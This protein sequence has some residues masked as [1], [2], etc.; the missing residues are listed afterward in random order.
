MIYPLTFTKP[1]LLRTLFHG[2]LQCG[3]HI[4]KPLRQASHQVLLDS[5][6]VKCFLSMLHTSGVKRNISVRVW[7]KAVM[8]EILKHFQNIRTEMCKNI[9]N[10]LNE[11]APAGRRTLW[12]EIRLPILYLFTPLSTCTMTLL[13]S[14]LPLVLVLLYFRAQNSAEEVACSSCIP[15]TAWE[16]DSPNLLG[17]I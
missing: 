5:N 6:L 14:D 7:C 2:P 8:D 11:I 17:R 13:T 12:R 3:H 9:S 15:V 1:P 10:R 4:W 16:H